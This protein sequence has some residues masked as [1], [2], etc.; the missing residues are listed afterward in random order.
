S[1]C[2]ARCF[3]EVPCEEVEKVGE[4]SELFALAGNEMLDAAG[5]GVLGRSASAPDLDEK[6]VFRG[7]AAP[8]AV[9][10]SRVLRGFSSLFHDHWWNYPVRARRVSKKLWNFHGTAPVSPLEGVA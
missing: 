1:S 9:V 2:S 4:R 8:Q 10:R 6:A 5:H 7:D 3:S